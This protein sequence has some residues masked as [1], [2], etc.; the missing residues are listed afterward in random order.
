MNDRCKE[1]VAYGLIQVSSPVEPFPEAELSGFV[2]R[3]TIGLTLLYFIF[4]PP[5]LLSLPSFP[6]SLSIE[7]FFP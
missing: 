6:S 7:N 5:F 3:G 2:T 1:R 4:L